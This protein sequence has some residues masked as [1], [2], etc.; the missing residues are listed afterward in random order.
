MMLK[1]LN[2]ERVEG[3]ENVIQISFSRPLTDDEMHRLDAVLWNPP[4]SEKI[5]DVLQ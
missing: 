2:I 5:V 1:K 3:R 4:P